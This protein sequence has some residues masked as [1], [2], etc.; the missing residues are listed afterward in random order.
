MDDPVNHP[1]HYCDHPSGIECIEIVRHMGFNIGNAIKYLW[2][3]G[4]K[5][6]EKTIEDLEK[7]KFYIEDEIKKLKK[8]KH[9]EGGLVYPSEAAFSGEWEVKNFKT[10][11]PLFQLMLSDFKR[12]PAP[13]ISDLGE[14]LKCLH[15]SKE[16]RWGECVFDNTKIDKVRH[17][18]PCWNLV[19][20]RENRFSFG[21]IKKITSNP[22]PF[23]EL[24]LGQMCKKCAKSVQKS[25]SV[26]PCK[27]CSNNSWVRIFLNYPNL[28]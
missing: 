20:M 10:H 17:C 6:P 23:Y 2:R 28:P 14:P 3:H 12:S 13:F 24:A 19:K 18:T 4:K 25:G 22:R 1:K 5:D 9:S 11:L 8:E 27:N 21:N 16:L 26:V 7:A 15:C